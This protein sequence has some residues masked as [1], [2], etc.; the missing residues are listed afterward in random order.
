MPGVKVLLLGESGRRSSSLVRHLERSGCDCWIAA[1][2]EEALALIERH[3]FHLILSTRSIRETSRLLAR[4]G[5]SDC[6]GFFFFPVEDGGWWVPL[7]RHGHTCLGAPAARRSEFVG[8]LDELLREIG[9][10][11]ADELRIPSA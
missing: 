5:E 2:T 4:C 3:A 10:K 6:S 1:S 8:L 9:S 11:G 7:V